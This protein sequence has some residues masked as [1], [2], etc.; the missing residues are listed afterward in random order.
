MYS[1]TASASVEPAKR[2]PGTLSRTL[3]ARVSPAHRQQRGKGKP[4]A[5]RK[6]RPERRGTC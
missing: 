5:R 1:A 4:D 6:S 2:Y 3:A